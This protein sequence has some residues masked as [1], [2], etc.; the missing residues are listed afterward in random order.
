MVQGGGGRAVRSPAETTGTA[1]TCCNVGQLQELLEDWGARLG[2]QGHKKSSGDYWQSIYPVV[3]RSFST[4][5]EQVCPSNCSG[6]CGM[7]LKQNDSYS[8]LY[9]SVDV[10]SNM[11]L[12]C[13]LANAPRCPS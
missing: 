7:V 12:Y 5:W 9:Y 8:T 3:M 13:N 11:A 1:S 10:K 2:R 4:P 6:V